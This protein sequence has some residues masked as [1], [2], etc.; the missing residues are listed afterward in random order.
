MGLL[1]T[2]KPQ[3]EVCEWF[4][5]FTGQDY[6]SSGFVSLRDVNLPEG[7][8][9]QFPHSMEPQLRKLGMPTVLK[10]GDFV[11]LLFCLGKSST[12]LLR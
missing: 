8:L 2:N 10:K 7:P 12:I 11:V 6:A 1:F 5:K 9:S 4:E 3:E